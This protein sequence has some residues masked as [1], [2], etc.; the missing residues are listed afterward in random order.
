MI[1]R[2]HVGGVVPRLRIRPDGTAVIVD[3]TGAVLLEETDHRR[4]SGLQGVEY[5]MTRF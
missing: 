1:K 2:I 4:T 3:Q 5:S